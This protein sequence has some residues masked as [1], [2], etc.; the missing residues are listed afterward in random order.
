[1][2]R[3]AFG[4]WRRLWQ[5]GLPAG[6]LFSI[7]FALVCVAIATFVRIGL[8][9]ISP[10][11]AVFAP[12]YSATLVAALVGGAAAGGVATM[13][14]ALTAF[15]L[16]VPADWASHAFDKEQLVSYFL[17]AASSLVIIWAAHSYRELLRRLRDEQERR[18]L[19]NHELA[20]RIRNTLAIV[21]AVAS[22]TLHDQPG[23]LAKLSGRVAALAAT[24]DLLINSEWRG[25]PLKRLLAAEFAPYDPA[26]F[27]LDG[28]DFE[29]PSEIATVLALVF[30][31]L[32]TN[33]AKYGALS[34]PNG[35]VG[36]SWAIKDDRLVFDWTE[37]GGPRPAASPRREGFGTTLIS[38]GLQQFAGAVEMRFD[39]A[40]LSCRI[41]LT[42]PQSLP[43]NAT[44]AGREPAPVQPILPAAPAGTEASLDAV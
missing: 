4:W 26:R 6:S 10:A 29:C 1:M 20:H 43:P 25:A 11:S 30:H 34:V 17:F 14:G 13:A 27:R 31:E 16:F 21:Q 2:V 42:L 23:T 5:G 8:G 7:A 12:Y 37:T 36:L 39:P 40:G 35:R 24:N 19:L 9:A 41:A 22:Q 32:T 38:K 18:A 15:W 28:E 3:W 33:A 44:D